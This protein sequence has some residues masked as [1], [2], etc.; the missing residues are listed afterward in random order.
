MNIRFRDTVTSFNMRF[1]GIHWQQRL[2][3]ALVGTSAVRAQTIIA[4]DR[5]SCVSNG[6]NVPFASRNFGRIGYDV[7]V[8]QPK[9]FKLKPHHADNTNTIVDGTNSIL[10]E[11]CASHSQTGTSCAVDDSGGYAAGGYADGPGGDNN[12]FCNFATEDH[13]SRAVDDPGGDIDDPGGGT[14]NDWGSFQVGV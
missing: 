2:S 5:L 4:T 6:T 14:I 11:D 8:A 10:A 1:W 7:P 3:C 13:A 12:S 9:T